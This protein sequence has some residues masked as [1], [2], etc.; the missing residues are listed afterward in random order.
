MSKKNGYVRVPVADPDEEPS[1]EPAAGKRGNLQPL[2]LRPG[3]FAHFGKD[4]RYKSE[5]DARSESE[6]IEMVLIKPR[7]KKLKSPKTKKPQMEIIEEPILAGDT[8]QRISLRYGCSVST[9]TIKLIWP[10]LRDT[11]CNDGFTIN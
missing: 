4:R 8:I 3:L 2:D 9:A 10:A 7:R 5:K 1:T 6:G 11:S